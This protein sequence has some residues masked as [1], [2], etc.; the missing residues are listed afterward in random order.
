MM[1][2]SVSPLVF[3][4]P[5]FFKFDKFEFKLFFPNGNFNSLNGKFTHLS[6]NRAFKTV[7]NRKL[8]KLNYLIM[9]FTKMYITLNIKSMRELRVDLHVIT[10]CGRLVI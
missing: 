9:L 7:L 5:F 6:I 1:I 2:I 4:I 8:I 10:I 3:L